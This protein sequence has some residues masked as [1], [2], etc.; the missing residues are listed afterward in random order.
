M[1][2]LL[3]LLSLLFLMNRPVHAMDLSQGRMLAVPVPE[4]QGPPVIDGNLAEWDLS[5]AEDVWI[6]PET[7]DRYRARLAAMYGDTH[8]YLAARVRLPG[9][10]LRNANSPIDPFWQGDCLH[11]RLVS[12]PSFRY[13][14]TH[15]TLGESNRVAHLS[16]WKDTQSGEDHLDIAYGSNFR[17]GKRL[18]PPEA[19]VIVRPEGDG[20][21]MEAAIPWEVLNVPGG[22]NPFAPGQAMTFIAE[23]LWDHTTQRVGAI[24]RKNPGVFAF[25]HPQEWGQLEFSPV[26]NLAPRHPDIDTY[27]AAATAEK[28]E[29]VPIALKLEK[30]AKVSLNILGP[31]GEVIRELT[32]GELRPAGEHRW[33][34]DG[35]DQ[36]G[37]PVKPGEYRWGAYLSQG[38]KARWIGSVGSSGNPPYPTEDGRGGWGGD[39]GDPMDTAADAGGLYFLWKSAEE[40]RAIV[41]VDYD[42]NTVWRTTP[43]VG[44]GFGPF[45]HIASNGKVLCYV[46][47]E[48]TVSIGRLDAASGKLLKWDSLNQP[49]APV[50]K[51]EPVSGE[52]A[53]YAPSVATGLAINEKEIFVSVERE[54]TVI[55]LDAHTGGPVRRLAVEAPR[56]LAFDAAGHLYVVSAPA[57]GEAAVFRI[58][59]A[60]GQPVKVV[61]G[62][63][64]APWDVAVDETGA[65]HLSDNGSSQQL[66][67]FSP[68]GRL[69]RTIGPEGGRPW[70]G[71]YDRTALLNP[72]GLVADPR[73]GIVLAESSIPKPFSRYR[74]TDGEL[75][76]RWFGGTAY[77]PTNIP[78]PENP[79]VNYYSLSSDPKVSSGGGFARATIP[80]KGGTG[81]PDAYWNLPA[82]GMPGA[83]I[84]LDT[85]N[86]PEIV[87]AVN[88]RQYMVSDSSNVNQNHGI[89]EKQG[90]AF[91]PV[92][93]ARIAAK[94]EGFSGIEFWSD[95]NGDRQVQPGELRRLTEVENAPIVSLA[96]HVGSMHMTPE[97][98]LYFATNANRILKVP[99]RGFSESGA[100]DWELEKAGYVVPT[101]L[102]SMGEKM[103]THYREG[104]LGM[105]LDA[106]KNLYTLFNANA[107]YATPEKTGAMQNG[108][109]HTSRFTAV[110]FA[111]FDPRGHLLWMAGRKA[112]SGARPGE[113]YHFWA[114]A[115]LVNDRYVAGGSE[116]GQIYFYTHDGFFVDALMDD[117]AL[118]LPAGPHTFGGETFSGR[119]HYFP[120]RDEVWAYTMGRAFIVDGFRGGKV[121]GEER[122][123]GS[124]TLDR[125]YDTGAEAVAETKPLVIA[126]FGTGDDPWKSV[127]ASTLH[128]NRKPLA[129]VRVARDGKHLR[130]RFD[131]EN[132]APFRNGSQQADLAFKGG[133]AV[134][135]RLGPD[136]EETGNQPGDI[137]LLAT[138]LEGKPTLIAYKPFTGLEPKAPAEYFT[139]AAGK[140]IFEYAAAVPGGEVTFEAREGGYRMEFR[141]PL[142]FL[143]LPLTPGS[144]LRAEAEV[145]LSGQ[146]AR[147]LQTMSRNHLFSP[148]SSATSMTDDVVTEARLHRRYWGRAR[149]EP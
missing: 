53:P 25:K 19:S 148:T 83:G 32:G 96:R 93:H 63:L 129:Q 42:G 119:V 126:P 136:T 99:T 117:P 128:R 121:E 94:G 60:T 120:K 50:A 13:P 109:G 87:E 92:A 91:L 118:G 61:S 73:G 135:L 74:A 69:L 112:T 66:K 131:V 48:K 38:L 85:M 18:D 114:M 84:V 137:R 54:N 56:G 125:V 111:K 65:L 40:E 145:L 30:P 82:A 95:R 8:L 88:G 106:E 78:D 62:G 81:L 89:V 70:T 140:E 149:V 49:L 132:G 46:F 39:H 23:I 76:H 29:G 71:A 12:D 43:F 26:G 5:G 116:W 123:S 64:V 59:G 79:R 80:E 142:A 134:G 144:E 147:G 28:R 20:Y 35:L 6:T 102:E 36:W 146:G 68:E 47:G 72:A 103:Y 15:E 21:V 113:M 133:D 130:V 14:A 77:G 10:P 58:P 45:Y 37:A 110:K 75:L 143:E 108:I 16:I 31:R 51:G 55:V 138:V 67:V 86:L 104:I 27:L 127:P 124:V 17:Q 4:K 101:V 57:G 3:F 122:R 90:D 44:G 24:Y 34:W 97:G 9:R 1:K 41:K 11:F 115:G 22:R 2:R 100:P 105:R 139:P 107:P 98:D 33:Y 52:T 141:L 7:A